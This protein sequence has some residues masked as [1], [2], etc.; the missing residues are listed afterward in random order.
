MERHPN[1]KFV[2]T[3]QSSG[4][5]WRKLQ[6][7]DYAYDG[8]YFRTDYRTLIRSKPSEYFQ[9]QCYLGS[10]IFSR[11]EVSERHQIGLD[12][13]M[14]GMDFPHHEGTL[15]ETTQEYLRATFGA[16][17]VPVNEA[18]TML[19]LSAADVFGFDL[20]RLAPIADRIGPRP[21]DILTPPDK[22]LFPRGDV[23]K[24]AATIG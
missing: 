5:V 22:D 11:A 1:L 9:R 17:H 7:L 24:P 18:R 21:R 16:E 20:E 23:N 6:N 13:M 3:E 15:I 14:I 19:G 12:K 10:S 4:W 2:F 8:S